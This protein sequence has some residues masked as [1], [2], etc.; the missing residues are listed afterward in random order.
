MHEYRSSGETPETTYS[1]A[2]KKIEHYRKVSEKADA[3]IEL[4]KIDAEALETFIEESI[5]NV[6]IAND[7][8]AA[9][10]AKDSRDQAMT[11]IEELLGVRAKLKV[12]YA[13][14]ATL[15]ASI[16]RLE[17]ADAEFTKLAGT[18]DKNKPAN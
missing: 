17:A 15:D 6:E 7:L 10:V 9:D 16:T 11:D 13:A 3:A 8:A 5:D 14:K 1:A 18:T 12:L 4:L 2:E